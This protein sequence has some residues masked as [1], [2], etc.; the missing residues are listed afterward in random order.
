MSSLLV[1]V[2]GFPPFHQSLTKSLAWS[3]LV[4]PLFSFP[5]FNPVTA[6]TM[7][8]ASVVFVGFTAISLAWY[9]V[10]GKKNYRGPP[11]EAEEVARR[12]SV[13]SARM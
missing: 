7:N 11:T 5:F 2:S 6:E 3:L 1:G 9:F 8:Y 12:A 10:W 13:L 4:T